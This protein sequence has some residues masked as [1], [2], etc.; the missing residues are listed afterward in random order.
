MSWGGVMSSRAK[1]LVAKIEALLLKKYGVTN[2]GAQQ[3][4]FE[5]H[6]KNTD[7][8]VD[9]DE[10]SALLKEAEVGSGITRG[11]WVRGVMRQMDTDG[12]GMISWDEYRHA[13]SSS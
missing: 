11:I 9:A 2:I 12:D 6:D 3:R 10:L 4:L 7:G 8:K 1:E 5:S 13:V